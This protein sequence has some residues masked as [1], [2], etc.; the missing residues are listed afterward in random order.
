MIQLCKPS[1]LRGKVA[2]NVLKF[3]AFTLH[4]F[5]GGVMIFEIHFIAGKNYLDNHG[6]NAYY[7]GI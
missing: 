5:G 1:S 6:G 2:K 4:Q 3:S 7:L